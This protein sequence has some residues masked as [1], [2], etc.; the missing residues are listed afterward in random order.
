MTQPTTRKLDLK[1]WV[2][3]AVAAGLAGVFAVMAGG[4]F[5]AASPK[6][7]PDSGPLRPAVQTNASEINEPKAITQVPLQDALAYD[8]FRM[9]PS[10]QT[11]VQALIEKDKKAEEL[12]SKTKTPETSNKKAD[13]AQALMRLRQDGVRMI[14]E[15]DRGRAALI[16]DRIVREGEE[17]DGYRVVRISKDGIDLASDKLQP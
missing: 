11:Q 17:I 2:K 16:G 7:M 6:A 15:T 5:F 10:I 13:L 4:E 1:Q 9:P 12:E 14:V 3:V 8:P